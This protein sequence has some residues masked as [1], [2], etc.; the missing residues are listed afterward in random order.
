MS[1]TDLDKTKPYSTVYGHPFAKYEQGGLSYDA[2]GKLI[3]TPHTIAADPRTE[4]SERIL[5]DSLDSAVRF[6]KN[7]LKEGALSKSVVYKESQN[8]NQDWDSVRNAALELK[9]HKFGY[10]RV[11]MWKLPDEEYA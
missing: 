8:N 10:K 9:I 2:V 7:I 11:E 4:A 5:T 1:M 3:G 6:L